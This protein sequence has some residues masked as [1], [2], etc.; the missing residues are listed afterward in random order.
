[1]IL[2]AFMKKLYKNEGIIET[3]DDVFRSVYRL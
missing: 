2:N 1:M 3:E